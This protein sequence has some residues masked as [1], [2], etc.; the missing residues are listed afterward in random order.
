MQYNKQIHMYKTC[1]IGPLF[2]IQQLLKNKVLVS[3]AKVVFIGNEAGSIALQTK[4][5]NFGFHGSQSALNMVARVLSLELAPKN[6]PVGVVYPGLVIPEYEPRQQHTKTSGQVRSDFAARKLIEFVENHL[7][8][9]NTGQLFSSRGFGGVEALMTAESNQL[10][11]GGA[12]TL[13]W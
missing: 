7:N 1:A 6:I 9:E 3:N 10:E 13:P 11:G 5:G 4:G 8:L 12:I 2:F